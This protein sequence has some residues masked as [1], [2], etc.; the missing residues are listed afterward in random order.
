MMD[1]V[2][3]Y[4]Y[5]LDIDEIGELFHPVNKELHKISVS[6]NVV[7]CEGENYMG[8]TSSGVYKQTLKRKLQSAS[9]ADSI[10]TVYLSVN[11]AYEIFTEASICEGETYILGT[12]RIKEEGKY[13]ETFKSI[14]GC[15][16]TVILNLSVNPKYHQTEDITIFEGEN[17]S[18]WSEP[19]IYERNLVSST[20]CDSIVT[21]RLT[22]F[23]NEYTEEHIA[24]CEGDSHYGQTSSGRYERILKSV[25]GAD[26]VIV[27]YLEIIPVVTDISEAVICEGD[28]YLFGTKELTNAGRYSEVFK[29]VNGCDSIVELNL[30]VNPK[31]KLTEN[32]SINIGEN[33]LGWTQPGV[34]EQKLV[35]S[36]GCDSIVVTN[37]TVTTQLEEHT[38]QLKAGWNII[39]SFIK[40]SDK[41]MESVLAQLINNETH[42]KV[43]DQNNKTFEYKNKKTGWINNIGDFE[44]TKGY[45]V[46]VKR[47][48]KLTIRGN[49]TDLPLNIPLSKG[50]NIISFPLDESVDAM[51]I[52]KPLIS[53]GILEKVQDEAGMSVEKWRSSDW[54]N[55]I[56]NFKPGKGYLV[57]VRNQGVLRITESL[58]KSAQNIEE[59]SEPHFFCA[60]Y[61]GNGIGHMNINLMNLS[62]SDLKEG[63]EIAVFNDGFCYGAIKLTGDDILLNAVSLPATSSEGG[64]YNGFAENDSIILKFWSSDKT[65]ELPVMLNVLDGELIYNRRA[66]VFVSLSDITVN[67]NE[68]SNKLPLIKIYPNPAE[69][70]I[71]IK[72]TS[73]V[74]TGGVISVL[75]ISGRLLKTQTI[76]SE[77]EI[78]SIMNLQPGTYFLKIP[79][80]PGFIVRKFIKK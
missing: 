60:D 4:N 77:T 21:T 15:D 3:I 5:S 62:D 36:T 10:V 14:T 80:S 75:D 59:D 16:S 19:G 64:L 12:Q 78:I 2:R 53:D 13:T 54:K 57:K 52:L 28:T 63:D 23:Q 34:D 8:W 39:S 18:G 26:S 40:P 43:Q 69:D 37:L 79:A 17:Y 48:T 51:K 24:V 58:T 65:E 47:N 49:K 42:V 74:K 1:E 11:S 68:I 46:Q 73:Q 7:I 67:T 25:S 70:I 61:E 45:K 72:F 29:T 27:T 76:N 33:Y 31:Y 9:G 41:K 30:S 66:S 71:N 35:S 50:W 20:G 56:G 55:G 32:I 6:E 38:I 44:E 22:V